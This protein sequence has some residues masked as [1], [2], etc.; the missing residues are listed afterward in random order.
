MVGKNSIFVILAIHKGAD[1][2][3][4]YLSRHDSIIHQL[5]LS[6][7]K[8]LSTISTATEFFGCWMES[9]L[10]SQLEAGRQSVRT[11]PFSPML[12]Y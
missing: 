11:T 12:F 7:A 1:F 4:H 9:P 6:T 5:M 10:P 2:T 3:H 8:V